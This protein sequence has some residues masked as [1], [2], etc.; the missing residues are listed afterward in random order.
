MIYIEFNAN[1]HTPTHRAFM[2][3]YGRI[4]M[5][6]RE[7]AERTGICERRIRYLVAG[8]RDT[9]TKAYPARMTY[10]EQFGLECLAVAIELGK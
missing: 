3:L 5:T 4:G 10:V 1:K 7:L 2:D 8:K 6:Q 9:P